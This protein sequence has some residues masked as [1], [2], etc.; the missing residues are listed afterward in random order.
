MKKRIFAFVTALLMLIS[1]LPITAFAATEISTVAITG[2][3]APVAGATPD[4][5]A[6][7]SEGAYLDAANN[8]ANYYKNGI[9]WYD[10]TDDWY[11]STN[12]AFEEGH[13][14]SVTAHVNADSNG[15]F[16]FSDGVSMTINGKTAALYVERFGYITATITFE[17]VQKQPL[18]KPVLQVS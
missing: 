3:D 11:V 12:E 16:V 13:V 14:Y 10:E 2:I 8:S 6:S 7:V 9:M 17:A 15:N 5:T 1:M 4:Y 18:P